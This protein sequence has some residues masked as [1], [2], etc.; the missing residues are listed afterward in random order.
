MGRAGSLQHQEEEKKREKKSQS[1]H[2]PLHDDPRPDIDSDD[3][4]LAAPLN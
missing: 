1:I 4:L 2:Q 3:A